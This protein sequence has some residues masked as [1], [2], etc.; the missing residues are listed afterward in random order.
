MVWAAMRIASLNLENFRNIAFARL[1]LEGRR[2]FLVGANGQGKS[3]LLEGLGLVTAL[4]S[5][6]TR[7]NRPLIKQGEKQARLFFEVEHEASGRHEVLITLAGGKKSVELD[8]QP[9]PRLAD[10]IGQFP[11]VCLTAEDIQ[12][13]RGSP[14][15]RRRWFDLTLASARPEYFAALARYHNAL[16]QRNALLKQRPKASLLRPY[17]RLLA[18]EAPTI[19]KLR[20]WARHE[21]E[22]HLQQAYVVMTETDEQPELR[23]SAKNDSETPEAFLAALEAARDDDLRYG[24]TQ[25]GPHRDDLS[26]YLQGRP[27][28]HYASD[29]QQRS[30]VIALRLAQMAFFFQR[31]NAVPVLLADDILGELDSERKAGFWRA[32]GPE[33]QVIA[34]G[35]RLP[36]SQGWDVWNVKAGTFSREPLAVS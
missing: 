25:S 30:T 15:L 12:L 26:F 35:T 3:N 23:L 28:R 11:S 4:R 13:L 31:L 24:T 5:F 8:G 20:R 2:S 27:A 18:N 17:D 1:P 9:L 22:K 10:F 34:S 6:R 16:S 29:G 14:G 19:N 32:I 33:V 21:I 7:D 36:A